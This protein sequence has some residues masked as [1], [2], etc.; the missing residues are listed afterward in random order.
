MN[1][2]DKAFS[3]GKWTMTVSTVGEL[4]DELN[5]LPRDLPTKLGFAEA[6]DIVVFNRGSDD[7]HVSFEEGGDWDEDEE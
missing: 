1:G 3:N 5:R 4:V 7:A 2:L 6:T